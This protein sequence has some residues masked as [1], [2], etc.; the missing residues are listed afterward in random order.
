MIEIK[1][2]LKKEIPD[3]LK[4]YDSWNNDFIVVSKQRLLAHYNNP[5][6]EDDDIV[7]LLAYLNH[8][9]VGYMGLFIDE[10]VINN[11]PEKIGWLSTWW[12]HPKTKGKGVGRSILNKMF[13]ENDG[14]I[15][16]SQFTPSA[17]RVYDK[18]GN[19]VT[20]KKNDG[21]K[22][23]LR[24]NS[25]FVL[26]I[27]A[28]K[29]SRLKP[30]FEFTDHMLNGILNIKLNINKKQLYKKT[31]HLKLD[32]VNYIDDEV[33]DIINQYNKNDIS[34]KNKA[35]FD[36][37]RAYNWVEK[38]PLLS[39]TNQNKYEFLNYDKDFDLFFIKI[40]NNEKCIGF[41]VLLIRDYV[42]KVLFTYYDNLFATDI[43]NII[44]LQAIEQNTREIIC[45]DRG[46]CNDFFKSK[47]FLY[48]KRKVKHAIISKKFNVTDFDN[49]RMN[50]GDGDCAFA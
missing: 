43:A 31:K 8:E 29:L 45:Y 49:F 1:K 12:V 16:V 7:L 3:L 39:L 5:K 35:F 48:K 42:C 26:P 36:W 21:I 33:E 9:L 6:I 47:I 25:Q 50:F 2:K 17:K 4:N 23:A 32:Y 27:L 44:K 30:F 22:A 28:P 24:S 37:M 14:K 15:G 20:L 38:A 19:F 34:I 18:S 40:I 10:I 41:I 11:K 13:D 46:V